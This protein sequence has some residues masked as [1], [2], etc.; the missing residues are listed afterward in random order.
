M[1]CL[2][3]TIRVTA[4]CGVAGRAMGARSASFLRGMR[5]AILPALRG[6]G[7]DTPA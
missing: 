4:P 1:N 7:I 5:L 6:P 3:L 2:T